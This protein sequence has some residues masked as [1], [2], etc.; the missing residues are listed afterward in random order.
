MAEGHGGLLQVEQD[1]TGALVR[2]AMVGE[3]GE[4]LVE[5]NLHVGERLHAWEPG[6]EDVGAADNAGGVLAAF[7]IAVVVVTEL[8]SAECGLGPAL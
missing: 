4:Y 3:G 1:T 5:R 8:L 2:E 7:V 6:A